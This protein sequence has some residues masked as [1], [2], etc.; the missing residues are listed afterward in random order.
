MGNNFNNSATTDQCVAIGAFA[1]NGALNNVDGT[2]AVGYKSLLT[3][4]SGGSNTAVGAYS[5]DACTTG[6]QNTALGTNALSATDDGV[7][8]TAIG[9]FAMELGNAGTANTAVG[10]Q[11]MIDVTGN[12]NTAVGMQSLFDVTSGVSNVAVGALALKFANAGE[13]NNIAIGVEAMRDV[14][15]NGNTADSNIALGSLAMTGGTLGGDFIGN[16]AIGDRA[17][18]A[19]GTN[20]QTGTIAIG[21]HSLT[22]LTSGAGNTVIG[23]E[24][25]KDTTTGGNNTLLGYQAGQ[26][27]L[28]GNNNIAIGVDSGKAMTGTSSAV[29]IGKQAGESINNATALGSVAVGHQ[30]LKALTSGASNVAVGYLSAK[31]LTTGASN[32]SIGYNAMGNS[33]LGCDKN[34]IIGTSAFFNGEVDEAVFIGFNAGGDGTTTTGANGSVGIGKSSLNNLTSGGGNTAIGFEAGKDTTTG[35]NNTFLGY[36]AGNTGSGDVTDGQ[37]NTIIGSG[38]TAN[39]SGAINRTAIGRT[40][41]AVADNSVTLGNASVTAVYMAQDSGA[42]VYAGGAI[43][44]GDTPYVTVRDTSA[45]SAGTGGGISLQGKDSAEN[46][47][48]FGAIQGYSIGN[49]NGGIAFYTRD[50]GSNNL[51]L[52]IDNDRCLKPGLDSEFDLGKVDQRFR[53]VHTE[54]VNFPDT[55]VASAD[56]NTLDDYEE[57]SFTP[58]FNNLTVGNATVTGKY[59]KIGNLVFVQGEIVWGSTTSATSSGTQISNLPFTIANDIEPFGNAYITDSG[60]A[61]Y[62]GKVQGTVNSTVLQFQ[63]QN[64]GSSGNPVSAGNVTGSSPFTWTTNDVFKF[65]MTYRV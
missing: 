42:I 36:Q 19:T 40:A 26:N 47:K 54:G 7:S 31:N 48:Q 59:T 60:T 12:Y 55:Q 61:S 16:I 45:Y 53:T 3:L 18:D 2:V 57:G 9:S 29:L 38:A 22:A 14:K 43:H 1:M 39:G 64:S 8:N 27:I 46:N 20:A 65:E 4:T 15:E 23:Y 13:S 63:E 25:G 37:A 28:G 52:I 58:T 21:H 32:V 56:A 34:V 11:S 35:S 6:S 24:A 51:A 50:L 30:S 5:L 44:A 10:S 62:F 17:M 49:N 33:H 41:T